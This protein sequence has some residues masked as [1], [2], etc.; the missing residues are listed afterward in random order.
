MTLQFSPDMI[1]TNGRIVTVDSGFS[2][3]EALAV[4]DGKIVAV[5]NADEV[6]NLAG[7]R[8][9]ITDLEGR[10]VVPGQ[11]DNHV[12]MLLAG[13]DTAGGPKVNI[14]TLPSIDDILAE[15]AER[16]AVTPKGQWIGTSCMYRGALKE[17]RFPNRKDLDK[18]A[19]DHPVYIFQSGKN[20]ICNSLALELAGIHSQTRQPEEP[21]G[22]VDK[23]ADGEPTGHLIAG[24]ADMARMAWWRHEGL[25]K[26]QWD[27]LYFDRE[28]QIEAITAQQA[29][30]HACGIVG[31][32]EMGSS[33]DELEAFIEADRRGILKT[34]MDIILGLPM[35]YMNEDEIGNAIETY[36]GPKQ[37]IGSPMLR[38]AGIKLV[39][40][41]DGWWAF[42][43]EKLR[44]IILDLNKRGWN[45]AIHVN[46]G[47]GEEPAEVVLSALE[48]ADADLPID[49]RRFSFE[50]GFGLFKPDHVER[51][52]KL[53]I[54]FG[55]NPLLAWYASARSLRM[56][57]VM[58][59]VRIAKLSETDPWKRTVRDWGMP[60][61]DWLDAG[62]MV[63][64]GT[65]NPAV[66]YDLEQPFLCQYS[67]TTGQTLAGVLLPGQHATREEMLRMFTINNAW[68]RFQE[69]ILGSIESG[70]YADLVVLDRDI[71]TC[72][73]D[74]LKNIQVLQT[75]VGGELVHDRHPA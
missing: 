46:T 25:P 40:V 59:Q 57:E 34:R 60:L 52:R 43:K 50:H 8:T 28:A 64:G 12:H 39:V 26:K 68:S 69:N 74:E 33:I 56:N 18:V 27:F 41:N 47:G 14:A 24:G 4:F 5:G 63:T 19:P 54:V 71:L 65:D 75:Y 73:D 44:K 32:R 9:Q 58:E 61:R 17:G 13:L 35:R 45:M 20:V 30:Y 51:A 66:V 6:M 21:E 49:G 22:W 42:S 72:S 15:I 36:F 37:H 48:E 3:A 31:V 10:C 62:V 11:F 7:E 16:V 53:G 1:L 2:I 29:I 67:A 23:D 70:K 55:A 38:I